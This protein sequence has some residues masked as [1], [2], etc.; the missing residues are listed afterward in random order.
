MYKINTDLPLQYVKFLAYKY[1]INIEFASTTGVG[2]RKVSDVDMTPEAS[3]R[4]IK[5]LRHSL[6]F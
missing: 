2:V 5:I 3:L 4:N 1:K 6:I